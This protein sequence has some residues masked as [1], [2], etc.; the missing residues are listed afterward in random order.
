MIVMRERKR[1][2][3]LV[4]FLAC[5]ILGG[6]LWADLRGPASALAELARL[7]RAAHNGA[8]DN[9]RW[10]ADVALVNRSGK[11]AYMTSEFK[12]TTFANSHDWIGEEQWVDG[13]YFDGNAS[14]DGSAKV[15]PGATRLLEN[16]AS[17]HW[18]NE[19]IESWVGEQPGSTGVVKSLDIRPDSTPYPTTGIYRV[20]VTFTWDGS[21]LSAE[22]AVSAD[23]IA[24]TAAGIGLY[25]GTGS[26]GKAA[27]G[28]AKYLFVADPLSKTTQIRDASTG[29]TI[30]TLTPSLTGNYPMDVVFAKDG[31]SFYVAE[32]GHFDVGTVHPDKGGVALYAM[33][34]SSPGTSTLV[35]R[36]GSPDLP[37]RPGEASVNVLEPVA[38]ALDSAGRVHI[39]DMTFGRILIVSPD[40]IVPSSSD[41]LSIDLR[42]QVGFMAKPL[43]VA[44]NSEGKVFVSLVTQTAEGQVATFSPDQGGYVKE[45]AGF[46][47]YAGS[48]TSRQAKAVAGLNPIVP[49]HLA[50]DGAG[51]LYVPD[52]VKGTLSRVTSD[53]TVTKDYRTGLKLPVAVAVDST[54]AVFVS[55]AGAP[56]NSG[57]GGTPTPTVAPTGTGGGSSGGGCNSP[58]L[59]LVPALLVLLPLLPGG[60]KR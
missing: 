35:R 39:A 8:V 33:N 59:A 14:R 51:T 36:I 13:I 9:P 5:L 3:V 48:G 19:Y 60:R 29:K 11:A 37:P 22:R 31:K 7:V 24:G 56:D 40:L 28:G 44:V 49:G 15:E 1:S 25:E 52:A 27:S 20:R 46:Y 45:S 30:T 54:G 23:P 18:A 41:I 55:Q 58:G 42:K 10:I 38:L 34:A 50:L 21:T 43:G 32:F 17:G 57:G 6:C 4:V 47:A 53:G 16:A 26:T 2:A 12:L